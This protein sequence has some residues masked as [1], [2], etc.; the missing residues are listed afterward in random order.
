[1]SPL[2]RFQQDLARIRTLGPLASQLDALFLHR[3]SRHVR[4]DGTVSFQGQRFE[5]PF[6][7]SGRSVRIVVD[8]HTGSVIAVEN[9]QGE[10]LGAA[11][12]LDALANRD[13]QRRRPEL[14]AT[15]TAHNGANLI[16]LAYRKY[17]GGEG[18]R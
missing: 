8:A 1:M 2:A 4:K 16:E 3:L 9:D 14:P 10:H 7:L 13:R 6:E 5:V 15:P 18:V 11:T 12:P 17:Y